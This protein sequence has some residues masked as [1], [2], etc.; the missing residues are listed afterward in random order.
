MREGE[1]RIRISKY[2]RMRKMMRYGEKHQKKMNK[3]RERKREIEGEGKR[4]TTQV[5]KKIGR[6]KV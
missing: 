5:K 2:G 6:K 3:K 4:D 1:K